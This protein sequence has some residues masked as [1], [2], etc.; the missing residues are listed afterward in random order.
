M[1]TLTEEE[2]QLVRQ[3]LRM[4]S[5]PNRMD[6]VEDETVRL[7]TELQDLKERYERLQA[8]VGRLVEIVVK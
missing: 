7:R 8:V 2:E 4:D 5:I 6:V 3:L 1:E